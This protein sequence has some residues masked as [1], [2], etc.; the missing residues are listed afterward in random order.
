MFLFLNLLLD[1]QQDLKN[2]LR[3][4]EVQLLEKGERRRG[5][6]FYLNNLGRSPKLSP[7]LAVVRCRRDHLSCRLRLGFAQSSNCLSCRLCPSVAQSS[8]AGERK[9]YLPVVVLPPC[10]YVV[11]SSVSF[12]AASL[13]LEREEAATFC[14]Y[15]I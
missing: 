4:I 1:L 15:E 3:K 13:S 12:F 2:I 5:Q 8:V 6:L 10:L 11:Q 14:F 9:N 7:P